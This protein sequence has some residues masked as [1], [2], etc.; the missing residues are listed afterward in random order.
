MKLKFLNE[1]VKLTEMFFTDNNLEEYFNKHLASTDNELKTC[2]YLSS[3][4]YYDRAHKIASS[5]A[6]CLESL[7]ASVLGY[8]TSNNRKVK[9][10]QKSQTACVY[11]ES[12]YGPQIEMLFKQS[13]NEFLAATK[14][15]S[16]LK[17]EADLED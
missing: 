17:F 15:E 1:D 16:E 14:N 6:A 7:D 12:I 9:Y 5:K 2:S 4:E 3:E 11:T 8:V 10:D 13:L